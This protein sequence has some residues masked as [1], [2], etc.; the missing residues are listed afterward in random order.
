MIADKPWLRAAELVAAS[1]R[2]EGCLEHSTSQSAIASKTAIAAQITAPF[3][4][5]SLFADS[6]AF[7]VENVAVT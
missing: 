7:N 3:P 4:R 2:S 5:R 1:W 6:E